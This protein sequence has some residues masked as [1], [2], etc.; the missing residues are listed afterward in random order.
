MLT[1]IRSNLDLSHGSSTRMNAMGIRIAWRRPGGKPASAR[2]IHP[3]PRLALAVVLTATLGYAIPCRADGL[4]IE[5][6]KSNG[7]APGS[8]GSFDLLLANS[9]ARSHVDENRANP[10][11]QFTIEEL[12][13]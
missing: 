7:V 3:G 1:P 6:P 5:A 4:V 2:N 9:S 11:L 12:I 8:T 10:F 13:P